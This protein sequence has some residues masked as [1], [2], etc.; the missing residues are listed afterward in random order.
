M[1][2]L[3]T[4]LLEW[5]G[6]A[7]VFLAKRRTVTVCAAALLFI[8]ALVYALAGALVQAAAILALLALAAGIYL[9]GTRR[10]CK[11]RR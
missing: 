1:K 6:D 2:G 11:R 3:L 4:F 9:R 10:S 8:A 5:L 7:A